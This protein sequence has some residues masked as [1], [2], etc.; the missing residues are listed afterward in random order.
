MAT[1]AALRTGPP[2]SKVYRL[3]VDQYQRMIE[4]GILGPD[5]RVEL[6]EGYLVTKM[7]HNPPHDATVVRIN[8][9]LGRVLP[10]DWLLR[11]QAAIVLRDSQPEPDLGI[12]RG[13]EGIYFQ[14]HPEAQDIA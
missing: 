12:V 9:R 6:L 13:P 14:R 8:R 7:P 11:V 5:D 4:E 1:A 2:V 3:T 10:E